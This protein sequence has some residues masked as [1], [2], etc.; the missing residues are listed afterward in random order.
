VNAEYKI[1]DNV[2]DFEKAKGEVCE[3]ATDGCNNY[4]MTNGKVL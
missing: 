1:Y 2:L 4:F 3:A